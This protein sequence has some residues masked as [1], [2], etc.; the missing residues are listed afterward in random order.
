M[1]TAHATTSTSQ[2]PDN[3][4]SPRNPA[5]YPEWTDSGIND[6]Q[7]YYKYNEDKYIYTE[8]SA[9]A[10]NE[11]DDGSFLIFF[12]GENNSLDNTKIGEVLNTARNLGIVKVDS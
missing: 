2:F 10:F 9:P 12:A 5:V 4:C 3:D 11:L 1:K 6:G 7:T 8:L